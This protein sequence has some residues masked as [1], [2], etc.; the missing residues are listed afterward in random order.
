MLFVYTHSTDIFFVCCY[1]FIANSTSDCVSDSYETVEPM[2]PS[3]LPYLYPDHD[4]Q[5]TS[6]AMLGSPGDTC[7]V[8][9]TP[10]VSPGF[11]RSEVGRFDGDRMMEAS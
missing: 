10:F 6:T 1:V 11:G 4:I 5:T 3:F 7:D 9:S 8:S 2:N